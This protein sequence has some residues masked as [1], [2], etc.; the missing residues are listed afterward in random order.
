[1]AKYVNKEAPTGGGT[2]VSVI[3]P[4]NLVKLVGKNLGDSPIDI[5]STNSEASGAA[6]TAYCLQNDSTSDC[7][8]TTFGSCAWKSIAGDTGAK[9]VC[10]GGAADASCGAIGTRCVGGA[11]NDVLDPGEECDDGDANDGNGC[12]KTCTLCGSNGGGGSVSAPLDCQVP[13]T[14]KAGA[15]NGQPCSSND[16]CGAGLCTTNNIVGCDGN[17]TLPAC[18]NN[19][20]S[21]SETCDD[22]NTNDFDSCPSDCIVDACTN[23][24]SSPDLT[25]SVNFAGSESVAGITVFVDYPEGMAIIPGSGGDAT[26]YVTNLPGSAG[27]SANDYDHA[28]QVAVADFASFP[29]GLLFNLDFETCDGATSTAGDFSCTVISAGDENL[30]PIP[31]VT[32]SVSIP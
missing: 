5:L 16:D 23:P 10:K 6:T 2:K 7:F 29:A 20:V 18:G 4:G 8:C 9:L 28:V 19:N 24:A 21:G 13:L 1:V 12:T 25:V 17:C 11:P 27:A 26:N 14:C 31:G 30:V 15:F 32:C 22:G 3:K